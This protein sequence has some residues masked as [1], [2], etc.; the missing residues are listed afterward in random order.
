MEKPWKRWQGAAVEYP[1][2]L[3][4][5]AAFVAVAAFCGWRGALPPNPMKGPRLVPW[6]ALMVLSAAGALLM[7]VHLAN[8]AGLNTGR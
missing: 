4:L 5:L 3:S 1:L 8:L 2:T 6:R 7:L